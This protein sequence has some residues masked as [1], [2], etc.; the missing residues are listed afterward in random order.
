MNNRERF[1]RVL[2]FEP[3]DRLPVIE[4]AVW[5][6]LTIDRWH[7][8]GL[9]AELTDAAEIRD[10]FGQD[11]HRQYWISPKAPTCPYPAG[12]G[13]SLVNS[14]EDYLAIKPHLYPD[15]TFDENMVR[16]WVDGQKNG[17]LVVW[18]SLEGFFWYPR[19]LFGIEPHM[20]AFY[21]HPDLMKEMNEDLLEYN[22]KIYNR[23][24]DICVPD[25]MTVAE[26][27]SYNHGP[28]LSR[29]QFDEFMAPYYERFVPLMRDRG[30]VVFVDTDGDITIP[31]EW[32][33]GVGVQGLLPLERMAGVDVSALR[34]A[35][36]KLRMLGAYD[37]T[38]MHLGEERMRQEFERL[39]PVMKQGGFIPS[40]DHQTPP[41]VSLEDYQL[42]MRLLR[43]YCEKAAK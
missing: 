2:N 19:T 22:I 11:A 31:A 23:F 9:P 37:K 8:E 20:Y 12:H 38:V 29:S 1:R 35:H 41:G 5:W 34:E 24:C 10:Y 30:T 27:M 39:L 42:Y 13:L 25:F 43:E 16:S 28:M 21:D 18:L 26:D 17:D 14:R 7:T 32:F 36:P 15:S 6:N 3:V 33:E 4:W 40:V